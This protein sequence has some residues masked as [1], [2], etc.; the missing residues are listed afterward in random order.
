MKKF[1]FVAAGLALA[2]PALSVAQQG[3]LEEI[4]V[5]A[6]RREQNLQEVPISVTAFSA[7]TLERSNISGATSPD[8]TI[9]SVAATDNGARFRAIVSNDYGS[10][11][12]AEA[13]LTVTSNQAPTATITSPAAGTLYSG[14]QVIT[15]K[16]GT[17]V[18]QSWAAVVFPANMRVSAAR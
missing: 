12:S 11:T 7:E 2:T 1:S 6:Q 15:Y 10:T 14:G 18:V 9:A 5:T 16:A 3:G 17:G 8:Y 13:V 4:I